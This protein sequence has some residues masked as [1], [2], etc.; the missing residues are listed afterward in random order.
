MDRIPEHLLFPDQYVTEPPEGHCA[1]PRGWLWL[2]CPHGSLFVQPMRC[3]WCRACRDADRRRVV[4]R[5]LAGTALSTRS[6]MLTL[7]TRGRRPWPCIMRKWQSMARWLRTKNPAMAYCCVKEEGKRHGMRHL[8]VILLNWSYVPQAHVSAE[9]RKLTGSYVVWIAAVTGPEAAA[10]AGK[11]LRKSARTATRTVNFSRFWPRPPAGPTMRLL[12]VSRRLPDW[13][14]LDYYTTRGHLFV[15]YCHECDCFPELIDTCPGERLWL[16]STSDRSPPPSLAAAVERSSAALDSDPWSN[17]LRSTGPLRRPLC[18]S[19]VT[20]GEWASRR[21]ASYRLP[22]ATLL[23][24]DIPP[25]LKAALALG[26]DPGCVM[27][28][29]ARGPTPTTPTPY[30]SSGSPTL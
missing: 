8:H 18:D 28:L 9:W 30:P 20:A 7:T 23:R 29:L 13:M 14:P 6:A 12:G 2:E 11:Y 15:Y 22:C 1:H 19:S 10:Y 24:P 4:T 26:L 21:G 25:G 27:E 5:I 17:W 3:H 16:A